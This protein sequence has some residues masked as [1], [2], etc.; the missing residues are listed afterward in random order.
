MF[1]IDQINKYINLMKNL[2]L[3]EKKT[4]NKCFHKN[5]KITVIDQCGKVELC[6]DCGIIIQKILNYESNI[7]DHTRC[8][9]K[10]KS[11]YKR[12]YLKK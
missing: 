2:R 7:N 5:K 8:Y 12:D 9:Y 6:H 3:E 4:S 10:K 1:K 11:V